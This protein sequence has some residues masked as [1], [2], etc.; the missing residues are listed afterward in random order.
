MLGI[1][2]IESFW[3]RSASESLKFLIDKALSP[4]TVDFLNS[5]GFEAVRV[6]QVID[7]PKVSDKLIFE[8]AYK[9][10]YVIITADVDFGKLL[11]FTKNKKPSVIILRITDQLISNVTKVLLNVIPQMEN[12]LGIGY[13]INIEDNRIKLVELPF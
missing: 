11:A 7:K 3:K 4:K 5:N 13:L 8:Y 10:E 2:R 6:N 9:E 12:E 1:R